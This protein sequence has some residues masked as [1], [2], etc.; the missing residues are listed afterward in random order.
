MSKVLRVQWCSFKRHRLSRVL[1]ISQSLQAQ[2]KPLP[3]QYSSLPSC[4]EAYTTFLYP[5]AAGLGFKQSWWSQ[6]Y[7]VKKK[8]VYVILQLDK[9]Y[10]LTHFCS[11]PN[12]TQ[13]CCN[14]LSRLSP[15]D[16]KKI[17]NHNAY[18]I[19]KCIHT[20]LS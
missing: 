10:K 19:Y 15:T 20:V 12:Y 11:N 17:L 14:F 4:F 13:L 2:A 5:A 6:P 18:I 9:S 1:K 7:H 8:L 3:C 16:I